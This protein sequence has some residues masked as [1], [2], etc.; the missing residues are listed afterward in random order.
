M[1]LAGRQQEASQKFKR[2]GLLSALSITLAGVLAAVGLAP[3]NA[4]SQTNLD[5][6][7]GLVSRLAPSLL[8]DTAS[9]NLTIHAPVGERE[10]AAEPLKVDVAA[11]ENAPGVGFS[12]DYARTSSGQS[13]PFD[14]FRASN[15]VAAYVQSSVSGVRILTAVASA[16]APASYSYTFDVPE[17]TK[18]AK[19]PGGYQLQPPTGAPLGLV[20]PAWAITSD[21]EQLKTAYT[22]RDNVLTQTVDLPK[23]DSAYPVLLDPAWGYTMNFSTGSSSPSL[24]WYKIHV[25]FNCYFPVDGA[26]ISFPH[27]GQ[28]LPLTVLGVGN[29]HCTMGDAFEYPDLDAY[30]YD[31][32]A[33]AGHVDGYG[34][35]VTFQFAAPPG[36]GNLLIVSA[37]IVNDFPS[38]IKGA[39]LIGAQAEWAEFASNLS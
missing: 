33:A 18:F 2:A 16:A 30:Q 10:F 38:P 11:Q 24:D 17:G 14:V 7:A 39:Y 27:F 3:A 1:P 36:A 29:F 32:L 19:S 23:R 21:G 26:P 28:D 34:S 12:V 8:D 20:R 35:S 13:G 31:F 9:N 15:D 22:W 6:A 5:D 37:Y 4:V 25:C